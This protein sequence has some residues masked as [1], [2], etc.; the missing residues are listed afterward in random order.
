MPVK[1]LRWKQVPK[2]VLRGFCD[3]Q[4]GA[5]IIH[6]VS[7]FRKEANAWAA[8]PSKPRIGADGQQ[9]MGNNGKP[10][11]SPIVEWATREASEKFSISV[12]EAIEQDN[13][14]QTG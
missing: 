3:V 5:M 1:I 13:P 9:M 8:L 12:I 4:I 2:N 14:G 11:W 6:D 7:I 10:L